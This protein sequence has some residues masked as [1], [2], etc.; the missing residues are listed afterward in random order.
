[1]HDDLAASVADTGSR[2]F[3]EQ[4]ISSLIALENFLAEIRATSGREPMLA[5][6]VH[7][8]AGLLPMKTAGFYFPKDMDFVLHTTPAFPATAELKQLVDLTIESGLFGWT[9]NH[10]RPA[11]FKAP[12]G[13]TTLILASLR[14]RRSLLGMFTAILD[15]PSASGWDAYT[16]ILTTFLAVTANAIL[17]EDTVRQLRE[18]N[19]TLDELLH[20]QHQQLAVLKEALALASKAKTS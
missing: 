6:A 9:L 8:L 7:F 17:A 14:S 19:R 15:T 13:K 20:E 11:A 18:R 16:V 10:S 3:H 12:D 1:M 2:N 5:L 4:L